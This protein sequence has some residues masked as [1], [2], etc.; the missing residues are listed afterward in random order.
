MSIVLNYELV[1]EYFLIGD[2]IGGL[3]ESM[4]V[5]VDSVV[6][7]G[8]FVYGVEKLL[9][10]CMYFR[11]CISVVRG[12]IEEEFDNEGVILGDEKVI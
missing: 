10:R 11:I 12:C 9:F 4:V 2:D 8:S 1:R 5:V 6:I 3:V 7:F